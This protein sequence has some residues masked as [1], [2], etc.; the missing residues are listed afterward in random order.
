M[1]PALEPA[2]DDFLDL[3]QA[4]RPT[5]SGTTSTRAI[6]RLLSM[7]SS[8]T[9]H[10]SIR[11]VVLEGLLLLCVHERALTPDRLDER[12]RDAHRRAGRRPARRPVPRLPRALV[13][14]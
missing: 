7:S 9:R 14:V 3:P 2:L 10:L 13:L 4:T 12:H 11:E 6:T 8:Q 1:A 5:A